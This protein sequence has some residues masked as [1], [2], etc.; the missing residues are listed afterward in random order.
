[1]YRE[2]DYREWPDASEVVGESAVKFTLHFNGV[3]PAC[4]QNDPRTKEKQQL[5]EAFE[6]QLALLWQ[7]EPVLAKLLKRNDALHAFRFSSGKI[8]SHDDYAQMHEM[9]WLPDMEKAD[10]RT[11]FY[12]PLVT[13][14]NGLGCRLDIK[15]MRPGHPGGVINGGDLDNRL[16]TLLDGLRMP[17]RADEIKRA[18]QRAS[19]KFYCL[20]EDDVLIT[21]L[22]VVTEQLLIPET[23]AKGEVA[24]SIGITI[25]VVRPNEMNR[26]YRE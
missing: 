12:I 15:F 16:K 2:V 11:T 25:H 24:L 4:T 22:S 3:L 5:R 14:R 7:E 10:A 6:P 23:K 20:L 18:S 17:H 9:V 8:Q 26:D 21:D 1:M 13:R 19:Q